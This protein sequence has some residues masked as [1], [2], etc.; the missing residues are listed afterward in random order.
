[1]RWIRLFLEFVFIFFNATVSLLMC[2][3]QR[4]KPAPCYFTDCE[5]REG[6]PF[7]FDYC[8]DFVYILVYPVV[9]LLMWF[10]FELFAV[11]VRLSVRRA[12]DYGSQISAISGSC[13]SREPL[14]I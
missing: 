12:P 4:L 3:T 1:M 9:S 7:V 2:L 10:Y 6:D 11:Y 13:P 14:N 8:L 5:A